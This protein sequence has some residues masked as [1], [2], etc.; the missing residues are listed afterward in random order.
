LETDISILTQKHTN[1]Y[2]LKSY[3][4]RQAMYVWC[5]TG[6]HLCNH[7]CLWKA[8]SITYSE[9]IS[10]ALVSQHAMHVSY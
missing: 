10:V 6:T 5:N 8:I 7:C 1:I 4:T 9:Y 2:D 3:K